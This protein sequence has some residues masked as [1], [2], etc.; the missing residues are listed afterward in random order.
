MPPN[1]RQADLRW[2]DNPVP[3]LARLAW[4]ISVSMLSHSLL[5]LADTLFVGRL[6]A[7]PLAAVSLGGVASFALLCFGWGLLR[8]VKVLVAQGVGAGRPSVVPAF[9]GAGLLLALGLG[10]LTAV[11]GLAA[12]LVL[13]G[14]TADPETGRLAAGYLS[15]RSLGAPLVLVAVALGE[16]R[17][18]LSDARSPMLANLAA[19]LLNL[20]LDPLLIFGCGLGV[21]GAAWSTVVANAVAA[22]LLW[23][24]QVQQGPRWAL[25]SAAHVASVVRVGLPLGLQFLLE[26][27]AF[28]LLVA[29]LAGISNVDLAAH[30]I[31]LQF[32]HFSFLPALAVGEAASVL[33][34]QAV[35]ANRDAGVRIVARHALGLA[36]AYTG[37]CGLL[38]AAAARPLAALF[39]TNEAVRDLAAQLL[40]VAAAF[41]VFDGANIVARCVL[42]GAGD[43]RYPAAVGVLT[44]W[45]CTPPLTLGLGISLG[46]GALGGWLGLCAEIV[47]GAGVLWWRFVK[48]HWRAAAERSRSA[49]AADGAHTLGGSSWRVR[50]RAQKHLRPD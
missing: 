22:G 3:E 38:F 46:W 9:L 45:V 12:A 6:G 10:A 4:P 24:F 47:L 18:G 28:T 25:P 42:R 23:R 7:A 5:T 50:T 17:Q 44:A 48:G 31:A 49:L 39:T 27:G 43:V 16:A 15:V 34:A 32:C 13:P 20:V 33:S 36:I 26:L 1:H 30:Q 2:I 21:A 41:Q 35:G 40:Y 37:A 8:A 14:L 29:I 11:G 19:N